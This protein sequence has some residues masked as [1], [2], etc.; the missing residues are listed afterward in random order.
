[1]ITIDGK[2]IKQEYGCTLL[3]G[4]FDSL[5]RYPGRKSVA[6]NNWAESDGIEPDLSDVLFEPRKIQ[7]KFLQKSEG[8][9]M[10]WTLYQRL[11]SD[12]SAP[13]FRTL[14]IE[15][16]TEY[17]IRLSAAPEYSIPAPFNQNANH[18]VFTLD[19]T[20]DT[21]GITE[22]NN[23]P[24]GNRAPLGLYEI[25]GRD[26]GL[27]GIGSDET[28]GNI[29]RYPSVKTPFTDGRTVFPDTVK[30]SHSEIRLPLWMAAGSKEEFIN[31]H[32]AFFSE[33][34]KTGVQSFHA[35]VLGLDVPVY[36][37]DCTEFRVEKWS[38]NAVF[39][40]FT[41]VMVIPVITFTQR[42]FLLSSEDGLF[43]VTE[44]DEKFID[45]MYY[46]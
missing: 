7:L 19:F 28:Q 18:T 1:M 16:M 24:S 10:F 20:D 39:A 42:E 14:N 27:Y 3:T 41:I 4:S 29:V 45:M 43:I 34:S 32:R 23:L 30:T 37:T 6:Y 17:S 13:G 25:N 31:N 36:Y 12:M 44:Q 11:F 21:T 38:D 35:G 22:G 5:F 33:I 2:D 46:G 26:F 40:R 8:I 15:N 9:G